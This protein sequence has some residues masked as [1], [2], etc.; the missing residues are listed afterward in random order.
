VLTRAFDLAS[1]L[2]LLIVTAPVML[3]A[4]VLIK[5]D[6][7][8]PILFKQ[9]RVGHRGRPFTMYKFRTLV[10]SDDHATADGLEPV[11]LVEDFKTFVF[12]PFAGGRSTTRVG[13]FLRLTSLDEL[14]NLLN[15]LKGEM[16]L[17]G[18]RP[19]VP[20]LVVQYPPEYQRRHDV[21]PGMTGLAQVSGR[22]DLTYHETM[23][24]DL[25]YVRNHSLQ[26]DLSILARTLP[27]LL[28]RRG[29]R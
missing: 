28:S 1:A 9:T 29:A 26:R 11:P 5:L 7:R 19:E 6:S 22:G 27:V 20:E 17:V 25:E 10:H 18:P 16:R 12:D 3:I 21:K 4:A 8:G 13:K 2:L 24:Y 14:P 15:V 23:L